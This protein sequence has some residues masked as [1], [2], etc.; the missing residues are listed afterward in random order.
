MRMELLDGD[1]LLRLC[2]AIRVVGAWP[3]N[4]STAAGDAYC[5][6]LRK[7][8]DESNPRLDKVG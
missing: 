2:P 3:E 1:L 7:Q 6:S 4:A 5:Q 8:A